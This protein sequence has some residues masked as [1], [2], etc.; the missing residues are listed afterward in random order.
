MWESFNG[1]VGAEDQQ[2]GEPLMIKV[3]GRKKERSAT[4]TSE[5]PRDL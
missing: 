5:L 2:M 4:A 1:S 3:P